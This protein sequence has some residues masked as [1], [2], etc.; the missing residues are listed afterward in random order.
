M[1]HPEHGTTLGIETVEVAPGRAVVTMA[2]D[3][4][5]VNAHGTCHGGFVFTLADTAFE[6]A[7]NAHGPTTVAASASIDFLAPVPVGSLLVATCT[8][9]WRG[10]RSGVYDVVVTD[11]DETV[12]AMFRG[13]SRTVAG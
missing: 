5:M 12:V 7:C 13:R 4:A 2:V 11:G 10:G 9:T 1:A 8:E 6:L 3:I